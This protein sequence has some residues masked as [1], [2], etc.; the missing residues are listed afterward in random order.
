MTLWQG[1][2]EEGQKHF[3]DDFE[4]EIFRN[5]NGLSL[6]KSVVVPKATGMAMS[7]E[8]CNAA[9]PI[10]MASKRDAIPRNMGVFQRVDLSVTD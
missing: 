1:M 10:Y 6:P 7:A 2:T 9:M 8:Y 4:R 5:E 3:I